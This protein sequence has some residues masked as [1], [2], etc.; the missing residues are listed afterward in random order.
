MSNRLQSAA[1]ISKT[2]QLRLTFGIVF[3]TAVTTGSWRPNADLQAAPPKKDAKF[4]RL[5]IDY[6]DGSEKH[7]TQIRWKKEMTVLDVL[8]AAGQHPRGIAMKFRGK[9]PTTFLEQLDGV[10]NQG[11]KGRN[12]VFRVNEKIGDR[13]FALFS[14]KEGDKVLWTFGKYP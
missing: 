5:V 13:S 1:A 6:G 14:V 8:K 4:V 3:L 2:Q 9:G 12:W 7:F 11:G 10:A